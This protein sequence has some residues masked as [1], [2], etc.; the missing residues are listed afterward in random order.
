LLKRR[1]HCV[2]W[3]AQSGRFAV[4]W[5]NLYIKA[6]LIGRRKGHSL[7]EQRLGEALRYGDLLIR[8][9]LVLI[10][11]AV[12]LVLFFG[13][14][15]LGSSLPYLTKAIL[16]SAAGLLVVH[17]VAPSAASSCRIWSDIG[18]SHEQMDVGKNSPFC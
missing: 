7:G 15:A 1:Q 12:D 5:R 17:R 4:D 11:L 9:W 18:F 16:R 10:E 8:P 13:D 6:P 2:K 14:P 3:L